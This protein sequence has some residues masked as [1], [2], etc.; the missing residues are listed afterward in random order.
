MAFK[1]RYKS[2]GRNYKPFA[3]MAII[4]LAAVLSIYILSLRYA[5]SQI[6]TT[7]TTSTT[8]TL[9]ILQAETGRLVIAVKDEQHRLPGGTTVLN[10]SMKIGNITAHR[11]V[12]NES[13]WKVVSADF[14]NIELLDY[15]DIIAI[16]GDGILE[17]GK[18]TQVRMYIAE[19]NITIKNTFFYIYTAKTYPLVIPSGELKTAHQFSIDQNKT[20]V[21]TIDFDVEN[22]VT[23]TADGYLLRPVVKVS[24]ESIG[25]DELPS[26]SKV[27][28]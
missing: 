24:E 10:I 16:I 26:N 14:K 23:H 19:A 3:I 6:P 12:G 11:V 15:T 8:T 21:I 13:E 7:T 27:I 28:S 17:P 20:T 1:Y 22:S 5:P 18:Y 4:A 9:P 2:K 25:Y